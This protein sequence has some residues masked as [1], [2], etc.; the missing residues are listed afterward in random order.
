MKIESAV[1][2]CKFPEII[3]GPSANMKR[4]PLCGRNFEYFSE[5]PYL[6][7]HMA[8]A[9]VKGVQSKDVSASEQCGKDKGTEIRGDKK[10]CQKFPD[11]RR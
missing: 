5:D 6:G 1:F 8:T 11:D 2:F 4:S 10:L 9:Y 3:L 7:A